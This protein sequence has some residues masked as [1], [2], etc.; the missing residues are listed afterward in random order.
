MG[1]RRDAKSGDFDT[2]HVSGRGASRFAVSSRLRCET[3]S[4][5]VREEVHKCRSAAAQAPRTYWLQS[6]AGRMLY[7]RMRA[8]ASGMP[9]ESNPMRS[10]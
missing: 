6:G 2:S 9:E 5:N 3:S 7:P 10:E 4:E 8:A 1:P